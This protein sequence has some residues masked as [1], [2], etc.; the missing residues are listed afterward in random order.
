MGCYQY[1]IRKCQRIKEKTNYELKI[2]AAMNQ[3]NIISTPKLPGNSKIIKI[4]RKNI[5]G[6]NIVREVPSELEFSPRL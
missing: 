6:L 1:S 5:S 2:D 3:L 4:I